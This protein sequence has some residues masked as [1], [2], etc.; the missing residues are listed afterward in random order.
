MTGRDDRIATIALDADGGDDAGE[1]RD[2]QRNRRS[3]R[4]GADVGLTGI[5]VGQRDVAVERV[6]V[7]AER[8]AVA[9]ILAAAGDDNP[10]VVLVAHFRIA[11][12]PKVVADGVINQKI[13]TS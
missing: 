3:G 2:E 9:E 4:C 10:G 13:L 11:T 7:R 1:G 6:D 12:T 8:I 5:T